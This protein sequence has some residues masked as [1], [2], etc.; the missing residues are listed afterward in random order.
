MEQ[1]TPS[2]L[3]DLQLDPQS[4]NYL[5]EAAR[6]ARFLS[7]VGF[8]MIALMILAG[9]FLGS[10]IAAGLSTMGGGYSMLGG[11]FITV[12]YVLFALIYFFPCFYL[13]HFGS[14]MRMAL[15]NNDQETLSDS[16]KNLKSC[17]KFFGV[18]TIIVLSFYALALVA[19]VIGGF[20]GH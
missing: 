5:S 11:G 8:I 17:F 15:R 14:K 9:L 16:L 2:D 18:F 4:G 13:F 19:V 20:A 6:W 7:I 1:P 10:R 12:L 3:F